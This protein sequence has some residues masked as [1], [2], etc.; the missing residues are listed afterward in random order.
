MVDYYRI[1]IQKEVEGA[2][3]IDTISDFGMFCM[4]DNFTIC[5]K[6]KEPTKRSW[7][8][9]DGD[10]EYIPESGLKYESYEKE[11]KFGFKGDAFGANKKLEGFLEYL[12]LSGR[13][14]IYSEFTKIGRRDVRL[15]SVSTTLDRDPKDKDIL[16]VTLTFKFN[17][18]ST[19]IVPVFNDSGVITNLSK[20]E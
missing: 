20:D 3:I 1:Y 5:N 10:D 17:D 16:I 11:I 14:K 13:I 12:R 2:D 4:E 9:S 7:A 19:N 15:S 18:P 6:I 8:D